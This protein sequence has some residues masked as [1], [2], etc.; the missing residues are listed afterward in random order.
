LSEVEHPREIGKQLVVEY[1]RAVSSGDMDGLL[2]LFS[3]DALI[4]QPFSKSTIVGKSQIEMF[5]KTVIMANS[6]MQRDLKIERARGGKSRLIAF[7]TFVKSDIL[8]GKFT[9]EVDNTKKSKLEAKIKSL[10]IEFID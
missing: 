2:R 8:K 7:V 1:F 5:L 9:F 3:D 10:K 6:G 4:F